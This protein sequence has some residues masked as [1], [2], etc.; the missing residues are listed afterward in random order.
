MI[1]KRLVVC[2]I[3]GAILGVVCILGAQLRSGFEKDFLYLFAFWYNRF[4]MGMAIGLAPSVPNLSKALARGAVIGILISFAFF[5]ST[6]MSDII[7]LLV[8]I[9]YGIIIEYVGAKFGTFR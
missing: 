6:G 7:G 4:V 8:G 3:A 2:L 9:V 5:I 1:T